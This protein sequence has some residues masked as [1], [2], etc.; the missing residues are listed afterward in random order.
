MR[1][2]GIDPGVERVGIAVVEKS[3]GMKERIVYSECFKTAAALPHH[4]RLSLIG[5]EVARV[6]AEYAPEALAIEK[7]YFEKNVTTAMFVAEA[8]G[9]MLYE[10][11][12]QALRVCEYTPMEIKVAVTGYGKSDKHA[13]MDMVGRLVALP[14]RK[15]IDD[16]MDAV[17]IALTCFAHEKFI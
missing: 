5:Q 7:L 15:M 12:R 4:E 2:L 17:A 11:A 6:I 14:E 10:A 16:E 9:V 13:V 1:I 8:R 3:G